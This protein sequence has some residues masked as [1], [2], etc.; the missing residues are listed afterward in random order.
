MLPIPLVPSVRAC[1]SFLLRLALGVS[2]AAVPLQAQ[3]AQR[4]ARLPRVQCDA[5]TRVADPKLDGGEVRFSFLL[6]P[7]VPSAQAHAEVRAGGVRVASLWSGLLVGGAAP[8]QVVWDGRDDQGARCAT[9][10]YT[11]RVS[12]DGVLPL[13]VPVSLVRLGVTSIE[14]QDSPAG[15][16]EFQMVYFR[17]GTAYAFYAT[18]AIGEFAS[19]AAP[20]EVSDLD[21]D[22]G[23]PR[24]VPAVHTDTAAP[25]LEDGNFAT[26]SHNYPLAYVMAASP[27]LELT[28]G[29][30]ATSAEGAPLGVGYP[31]P[32]VELRV[33]CDQGAVAGPDTVVPGGTALVDLPPLAAEVGRQELEMTLR[34]EARL[35]GETEWNEIPGSLTIPLRIYTLL[36]SP[37]FKSGATGLAYAGPWVEVAEYVASWKG[38]L[39]FA[40]ADQHGLTE[41]FVKG[42]F[43]Q[44]GGIPTAIEGV[45]YDAFPLGGD[46]G[47]T[48]YLMPDGNMSLSR[49]LHSHALGR[50]VNCTD[51]MAAT[52]TMLSMLGATGMRPVRL[53]NMTLRAIWGIGSPGYT[54]DLWGGSHSFSYHHIVTDD[55]AVTVSDTCMQLDEDGNPLALPGTPGWN[56][57]RP[58]LG[59]G[60]YKDLA[61][62]NNV[63]KSLESL[64]G[65]R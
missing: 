19:R 2:L 48:H 33:L 13:E 46:G 14:A 32:D 31:L 42:F 65:L 21:L 36:G 43:G 50:F 9:G 8:T 24:P 25:V 59:V 18:P 35:A 30:G 37:R 5:V 61:A 44:N 17:K 39:G 55:D 29:T 47:A 62:S 6:P 15:D 20:G 52:T 54:L 56:V 53:G 1:V 51:N 45:V 16:D 49:L 64:P 11:L 28:F 10:T 57:H 22:D 40:C 26:A 23:E 41:V 12:A 60:G 3:G 4:P 34:F 63:T 27:R 58:W 7:A 38:T